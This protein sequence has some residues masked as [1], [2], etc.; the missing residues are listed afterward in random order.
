MTIA[1]LTMR[2]YVV[3]V[4]VRSV[5]VQRVCPRLKK[6]TAIVAGEYLVTRHVVRSNIER[7]RLV[8]T[9]DFATRTS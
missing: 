3:T 6:S 2:A 8:P 5:N 1:P 4:V 9:T 7:N